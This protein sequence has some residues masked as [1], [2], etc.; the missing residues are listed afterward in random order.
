[1]ESPCG[2][3]VLVEAWGW[4]GRHYLD[5]YLC[6][7]NTSCSYDAAAVS[8]INLLIV[9]LSTVIAASPSLVAPGV[10]DGMVLF[11]LAESYQTY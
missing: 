11:L 5:S 9:A 3:N 7:C 1:M 10:D 4:H 8:T 2:A 6:R